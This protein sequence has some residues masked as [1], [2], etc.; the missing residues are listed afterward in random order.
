MEKIADR[1][2]V[3]SLWKLEDE[4]L[5]NLMGLFFSNVFITLLT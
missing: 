1:V 2:V 4:P 3:E 5:R